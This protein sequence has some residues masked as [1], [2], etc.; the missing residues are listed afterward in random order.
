VEL[1]TSP[2]PPGPA[3]P[4]A[5]PAA[6]R[7]IPA[8]ILLG[9][10]LVVAGAILTL[11]GS[12]WNFVFPQLS[13]GGMSFQIYL[14]VQLGLGAAH[15]VAFGL[16]LFL[17]FEGIA[18]IAARTRPWSHIGAI[19]I[20]ATTAA[21]VLAQLAELAIYVSGFPSSQLTY[22]SSAY[23]A[24]VALYVAGGFGVD[25]GIAL[26]LLGVARGFLIPSSPSTTLPPP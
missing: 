1:P 6:S 26:A 11:A 4:G 14:E 21:S 10:L 18:R 3:P 7:R 12:I 19:V 8:L 13:P 25:L 9:I 16:G 17:I 15:I 5:V 20:L 23:V 24:I 2:S 22:G